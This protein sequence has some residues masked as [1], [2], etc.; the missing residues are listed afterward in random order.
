MNTRNLAGVCAAIALA[1]VAAAGA[2]RASAQTPPA[3]Q[4]AGTPATAPATPPAPAAPAATTLTVPP[5]AAPEPG[6]PVTLAAKLADK[7][8]RPLGNQ[9]VYFYVV[10]GVFGPDG[11]MVVGQATTDGTGTAQFPYRPTWVGDVQAVA[12]FA[13]AGDLAPAQ[14]RFTFASPGPV[15]VH[16]DQPFGLEIVRDWAP[17][18]VIALVVAIWVTI[19]IV[20]ARLA[21]A[22]RAGGAVERRG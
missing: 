21:M 17:A 12:M 18:V 20:L 1:F 5:V 22:M 13:G 15:P 4:P 10:P 9:T 3:P 16:R 14:A 2:D 7:G 8:G 19:I 6:K 11:M